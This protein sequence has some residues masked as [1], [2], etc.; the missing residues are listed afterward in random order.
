VETCDWG[1]SADPYISP[2]NP[3]SESGIH[4]Q[5]IIES[6]YA[7]DSSDHTRRERAGRTGHKGSK[8]LSKVHSQIIEILACSTAFVPPK[9]R[10]Q[11]DQRKRCRGRARA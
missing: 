2:E 8:N 4:L 11:P 3:G 9:Q 1:G 10:V 6:A 5:V 7:R